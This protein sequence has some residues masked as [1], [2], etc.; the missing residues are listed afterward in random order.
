MLP[1]SCSLLDWLRWPSRCSSCRASR[2]GSAGSSLLLGPI[3]RGGQPVSSC[4]SL[5][6]RLDNLPGRHQDSLLVGRLREI[7]ERIRRRNSAEGL[8]EEL[9]YLADRDADRLYE[10]YA[11]FRVV[12]WAIPILGFLGTVVG[13]TL[14]IANLTPNAGRAIASGDDHRVERGLRDH[15]PGLVAVD[16]VDVRQ[17]SR[18]PGRKPCDVA[19]RSLGRRRVARPVRGGFRRSGRTVGGGASDE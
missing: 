7:L 6:G 19:G 12:I 10:S 1:R 16:R 18:H 17:V 11:L 13:I 9:K 3:A 15:D 14:A 8:D 5:L 4:E 2:G